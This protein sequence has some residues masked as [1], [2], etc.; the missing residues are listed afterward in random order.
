MQWHRKL[1]KVGDCR[2]GGGG[3]CRWW[4]LAGGDWTERA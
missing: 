2:R 3:G 1:T 4:F